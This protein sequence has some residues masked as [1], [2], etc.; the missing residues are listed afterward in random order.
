MHRCTTG[1]TVLG[2]CTI[3]MYSTGRRKRKR[4]N[5]ASVVR[6]THGAQDDL[7]AMISLPIISMLTVGYTMVGRIISYLATSPREKIGTDPIL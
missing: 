6:A 1:T 2:Y 7:T 5:G 4:D 3:S